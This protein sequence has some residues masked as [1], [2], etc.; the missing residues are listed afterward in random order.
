[1]NEPDASFCEIDGTPL[2]RVYPSPPSAPPSP[3]PISGSIG[4][5]V[6]PDQTEVTLPQTTRVFG[7]SDLIRFLKPENVKEVS[8]AHF[9]ITQESGS[10]YIQDGGPDANNP[11]AW[12]A[13]INHTSVNGVVL[14]PGAKH[15]LNNNDVIDVSQLGINLTFKT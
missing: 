8:R 6:M 1:M 12:K 11:Q 7:R 15:R 3:M 14:Q 10:F 5:F 9:T 4:V 2:S 13:S